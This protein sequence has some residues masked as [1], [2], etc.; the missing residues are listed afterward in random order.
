MTE[1]DESREPAHA[2]PGDAPRTGE[3]EERVREGLWRL[4]RQSG[5]N[6]AAQLLL[7][8]VIRYRLEKA[9]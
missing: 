7:E 8:H 4:F 1:T 5:G 9:T 3:G 6:P 2:A